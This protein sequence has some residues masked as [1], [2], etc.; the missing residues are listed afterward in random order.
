MSHEEILKIGDV[1][2]ENRKFHSSKKPIVVNDVDIK[3]I[4]LSSKY[5]I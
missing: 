3:H 1:Y 5:S 4:V 2:M